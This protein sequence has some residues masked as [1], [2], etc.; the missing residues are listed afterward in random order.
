MLLLCSVN[1]NPHAEHHAFIH[2]NKP[3][4][5]EAATAALGSAFLS[6]RMAYYYYYYYY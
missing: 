6:D 4:T 5:P 3:C 1:L 2:R